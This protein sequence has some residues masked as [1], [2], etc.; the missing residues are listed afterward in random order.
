MPFSQSTKE[1][2]IK[3]GWYEN[4]KIDT[5]ELERLIESRGFK[6]FPKVKEFLQ[7]YG[8]LEFRIH[9]PDIKSEVI[10]HNTNPIQAL[11]DAGDRR[12]V[13]QFEEL[14]KEELVIVGE[15][16]NRNLFLM[17]S[18]TGKVF[19]DNGKHGNNFEEALES[20]LNYKS[21]MAWQNIKE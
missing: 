18:E 7:E 1:L 19:C 12:I 16:H 20:I 6:V 17:I 10:V 15:L 14:A 4:R 11:G 3:S 13:A 2:L 8:M 5:T 21:C 9:H